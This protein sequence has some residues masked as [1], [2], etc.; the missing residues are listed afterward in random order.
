MNRF[1]RWEDLKGLIRKL[2]LSEIR[3]H[4]ASSCYFM[5]LAVFPGLLL[6]LGLVQ[7]T[8]LNVEQLGEM[9]SGVIP[10]P[11][12]EGAKDLIRLTYDR[13]PPSAVGLSA[14]T[15]LWP[16]SRGIYGILRG[17][18]GVYGVRETRGWLHTRLL[19]VVYTFAFLL[20]LLLTLL[21]HVFGSRVWAVLRRLDA[22]VFRFLTE[23][24]DLRFW[25][26]LTVQT[27]IFTA[28]FLALPNLRS[29]LRD[30]LPGALLASAGW[31]TFSN[32]YSVY[33]ERFAHLGNVY[34][35]VYAVALSMLWLYCCMSIVF[36]GG[37]LNRFFMK[38]MDEL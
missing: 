1:R 24:V 31:L 10:D 6:L 17:L 32:L 21:L 30:A 14:L 34:G 25:L 33:V 15:T 12:L 27:A 7:L 38:N 37:V 19:S 5:V 26:L 3:L 4:A 18:N 28:M 9:F 20:V 29:R 2:A 35:S 36:Y 16:A 23:W 8:D 11:F 22:P 13:L